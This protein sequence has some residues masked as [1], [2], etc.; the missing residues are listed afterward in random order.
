MA[1]LLNLPWFWPVTA[2]VVGVPALLIV[3]TEVHLALEAHGRGSA[4]IVLLLRNWV[5]PLGGML[6]LMSQAE[7]TTDEVDWVRVVATAFGFLVVLVLLNA[8]NLFMFTRASE[9]T[10]R[11]RLPKI[12]V[13]LGRAVLIVVAVAVIFAWVWGADVGGL[14]T[15][16]GIGSIVIGLA[17]QSAVGPIVAGLFLLFERPFEVGDWL[18]TAQGRG[19]VVE[20][21]WRATHFETNNGIRIVPNAELAGDSIVNLSKATNPWAYSIE[22]QFSTADPPDEVIALLVDVASQLPQAHPDSSPSAIPISTDEDKGKGWYEV[23]IPLKSPGISWGAGGLFLRRVWYAARRAGLHFDG[24]AADPQT[25]M[26][27][28]RAALE[29]I[30]PRLNL[31]PGETEQLIEE[32]RLERYG[33]GEVI[34]R[35]HM[36]PAG[37]RFIIDGMTR[38]S[39]EGPNGETVHVADLGI[40]EALGLTSL[41]RQGIASHVT[42]V[43]AVTVLFIPVE[44]LDSLVAT[45]RELAR[46]FGREIENRRQRTMEAFAA[47]GLEPPSGSRLIAY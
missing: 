5:V 8:V 25:S 41:L 38:M 17:L 3:L 16:L 7:L 2:V 47:L 39:A 29:R 42:A 34:Q 13:D 31:R 27:K 43:T 12:F 40:D 21:N 28:R 9:G 11:Q 36:I 44:T 20:I 26:K 24:D 1:E 4:R 18:I 32:V 10:W 30:A 14:F 35:P 37:V 46:G 23:D 15:A 33:E 6:V 45:H 19:R 22:V